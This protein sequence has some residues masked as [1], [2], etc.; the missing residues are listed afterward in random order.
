MSCYFSLSLLSNTL[1]YLSRLNLHSLCQPSWFVSLSLGIIFL[2]VCPRAWQW[3][4]FSLTCPAPS[5]ASSNTGVP[6]SNTAEQ[7]C[8]DHAVWNLASI[9]WATNCG[10]HGEPQWGDSLWGSQWYRCSWGSVWLQL[11]GSRWASSLHKRGRT[12]C[13]SEEDKCRL[14]AGENMFHLLFLRCNMDLHFYTKE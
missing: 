4:V 11:P 6:L 3:P 1:I 12:I 13:S 2:S 5:R 14:V 9:C 8:G 10:S 7:D